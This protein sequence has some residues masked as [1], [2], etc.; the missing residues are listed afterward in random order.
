[1]LDDFYLVPRLCRERVLCL[2]VWFGDGCETAVE[3]EAW[4]WCLPFADLEVC[5]CWNCWLFELVVSSFKTCCICC[6]SGSA[7]STSEESLSVSVS[8][9]SDP[10][11]VSCSLGSF[12]FM[13]AISLARSSCIISLEG[14]S[15]GSSTV[16]SLFSARLSTRVFWKLPGLTAFVR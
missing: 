4:V 11:S 1:M 3:V 5:C 8:S 7:T 6:S 12:P 13:V 2:G 10:E 15:F 9:A 16:G 14:W